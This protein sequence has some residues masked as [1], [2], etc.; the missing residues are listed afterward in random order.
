MHL[1]LEVLLTVG[2]DEE[3]SL[4]ETEW[5]RLLAN[6]I[7]ETKR[8]DLLFIHNLLIIFYRNYFIYYD[9]ATKSSE[10]ILIYPLSV[11]PSRYRYMV[12]PAISSYSFGATALICFRMFLH[13]MEVCMSTGF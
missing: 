4:M 12:C 8:F 11:R 9:P 6:Y 7:Q 5:I 3:V 13:I 1:S 2:A 10:G